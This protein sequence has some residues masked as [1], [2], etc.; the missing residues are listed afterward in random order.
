MPILIAQGG[1]DIHASVAETR[2]VSEPLVAWF[3]QASFILKLGGSG[4]GS[5]IAQLRSANGSKRVR[6]KL[7]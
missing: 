1:K 3:W 2:S 4:R 7:V 6:E 5:I